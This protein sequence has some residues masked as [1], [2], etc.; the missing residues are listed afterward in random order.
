MKHLVLGFLI[1]MTQA[2]VAEDSWMDKQKMTESFAG[3]TIDGRYGSGL[4]FTETYRADGSISYKDT[5]TN[6]TGNWQ[7]TGQGFCTFYED[8]NGGCFLVR[9]MGANCFEFYISESQ[10][11]GPLS[12]QAGTPYV[13]QGWYPEKPSTCTA[14]TT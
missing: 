13:A 6:A 10:D 1:L 4:A 12:P 2:A 11:T 7:V 14:L 8:M 9:Q 5:V 3:R